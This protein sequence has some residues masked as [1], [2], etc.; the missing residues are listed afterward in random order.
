MKQLTLAALLLIATI[1]PV[2]GQGKP[3]VTA[4]NHVASIGAGAGSHNSLTNSSTQ[5]Y[6][7]GVG[8]VLDI[9]LP[10]S[11]NE[12]STLFT[13]LEGGLVDYPLASKPVAVGGLTTAEAAAH[14]RASIKV[15][16]NPVVVVKVRD[17]ASHRV[18]ING[19]VAAPGVKAL[20][21]EAV[22]LYVVL[23]E[24]LV[25]PEAAMVT[26]VR[27]GQAAIA[28]KLADTNASSTLVTAGDVI[29]VSTE[30]SGPTEFFFTGGAVNSPGQ[31]P[32]HSGLTLT[33]AILASGGLNQN[34]SGKVHISRQGPYG[35]LITT[36]Y[37]LRDIQSGK[38]PDPVLENGDRLE[39]STTQ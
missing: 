22:P 17:Y 20:R 37:N 3:G 18:S 34:A 38:L 21:R 7:L 33:Q 26:I 10:G 1:T 29:R 12:N 39:I 24:A 5:V 6:K 27:K 19:F 16:E 15:L 32:Y 13:V 30:S 28:V 35:R 25:L 8:D 14:L 4:N 9:Q 11:P 23:S 2:N 36:D 31:K